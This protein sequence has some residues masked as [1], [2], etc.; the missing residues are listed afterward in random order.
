MRQSDY[1]AEICFRLCKGV[2]ATLLEKRFIKMGHNFRRFSVPL[3]R[4]ITRPLE[5]WR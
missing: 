5:N 2:F 3:R 4:S 1:A